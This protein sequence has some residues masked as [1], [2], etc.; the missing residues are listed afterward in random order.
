M[1]GDSGNLL[2][3]LSHNQEEAAAYNEAVEKGEDDLPDVTCYVRVGQPRI[4][5]GIS[6]S[7]YDQLTAVSYDT[8]CRQK[9]FAADFAAVTSIDVALNGENYSGVPINA[10][11]KLRV[12]EEYDMNPNSTTYQAYVQILKEE[13]LPAMGCTEP[14]AI[15]YC[16]AR[17]RAMLGALPD[18][19]EVEASG[20]IIKNVKGVK[21]P[22]SN[23]L[24]GIDVAATLGVVGGC[25]E[26]ELEVLED[27]TEADIENWYSRD[28]VPVL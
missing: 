28:S 4:V 9:L 13:L 21:V 1:W 22:N 19:I 16:A 17:A 24:K 10:E 23:G 2:L 14:I 18:A 11:K 3:R 6:E 12:K 15:A 8:L 20:N 25:A 5:Y 27:V 26:R 7:V